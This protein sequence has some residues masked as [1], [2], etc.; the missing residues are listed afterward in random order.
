M[1]R[2]AEF[3]RKDSRK[4]ILVKGWFAF[5]GAVVVA[6]AILAALGK[7]TPDMASITNT[8]FLSSAGVVATYSAANAWI[9]TTESKTQGA[10]TTMPPGLGG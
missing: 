7:L 9:N 10:V 2:A 5:A 4:Y 1:T 8:F 3:D 6:D